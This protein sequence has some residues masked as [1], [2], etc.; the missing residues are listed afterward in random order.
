MIRTGA[1]IRAAR[2]LLGWT[3]QNLADAASL[4]TNAVAYW[5]AHAEIPA[6]QPYAVERIAEALR[7]GG[8]LSFAS[9][10]PGVR[11]APRTNFV[12]PKKCARASWG[13]RCVSDKCTMPQ[14]W[15]LLDRS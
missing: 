2:A 14:S 5:E 11:L 7:R 15:R 9:P 4:H 6:R 12:T 13:L 10:T 1:Q 8:V 3:R